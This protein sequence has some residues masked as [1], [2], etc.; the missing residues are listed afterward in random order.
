MEDNWP[1]IAEAIADT[2]EAAQACAEGLSIKNACAH[3]GVA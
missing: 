3:L 2:I 1:E